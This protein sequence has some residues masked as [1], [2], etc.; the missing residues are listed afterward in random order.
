M[1]VGL[2]IFPVRF[3]SQP[4]IDIAYLSAYLRSRG[5]QVYARDFNIDCMLSNDCDDAF[6]VEKDNQIN[7]FKSNLERIDKWVKDIID[8]SPDFIGISIWKAQLY[9]SLEIAKMIK[10]RRKD[11]AIILGGAWCSIDRKNMEKEIIKNGAADYLV[12][13]E[14]ELTLADIVESG[15]SKTALPGCLKIVEGKTLEG[16][17]REEVEDLDSLPFPTYADF[18]FNKYLYRLRYP[19]LLNRGCSWSCT[20]CTHRNI[21]RHFR[22]RSAQNIFAEIKHCLKHYPF[23]RR[24]KVCDHTA[25]AN[26]AQMDELC[27]LI[28]EENIEIDE[29]D[30]YAQINSYMLDDKLLGKLERVGF[31]SWSI[32]IESGSDKILKSMRRPYTVELAKKV[33][34]K[35][36]SYGM[37]LHLS[38]IIGYTEEGDDDFRQTLDFISGVKRYIKGNIEAQPHCDIRNTDLE[39]NFQKY[40]IYLKGDSGNDWESAYNTPAIRSKRYKIILDHL[41]SLGISCRGAA[42]EREFVEKG[43][44]PKWS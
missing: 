40:G 24:F 31:K 5:H 13:G 29:V 19:I 6:W 38:F 22:S 8:F 26:L 10:S 37:T 42:A 21:W 33:L 39:S 14:G 41:R 17:W 30:S 27:N 2:F 9:F 12:F 20:F 35:M 34:K 25:N 23:I 44:V 28:I 18:D 1:R 3:T 7:L 11:I 16:G 15:N 4:P 36:S 32:G 43:G